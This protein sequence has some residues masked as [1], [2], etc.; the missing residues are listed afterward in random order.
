VSGDPIE[1]LKATTQARLDD[2]HRGIRALVLTDFPDYGN[3]GDSAIALGERAYWLSSGIELL[4][5]HSQPTLPTKVF[6]GMTPVAINGGGN[7]GGL[8]PN[9]DRHRYRLAERLRPGVPLV[10]EPQTVQFRDSDD[11]RKFERV[12]ASRVGA[13]IAVR[14]RRSLALVHKHMEEVVLSPDP[15]HM[16]GRVESRPPITDTLVLRRADG[17]SRGGIAQGRDWPNDSPAL[18]RERWWANRS[19]QIAP[20]K[21]LFQYT[22]DQWMSK[23]EQRFQAGVDYLSQGETVVTDRLH[24][25]LMALQMG[26]KV[27]AYDNSY[28]KLSA[29]AETWLG[30]YGD[31]LELRGSR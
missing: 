1:G 2:L 25:M 13:R 26:R 23:A 9:A 7:L 28:G 3:I 20:L 27:V 11:E 16:L 22:P 5:V 12:F 21:L 6:R 24:A 8:Y 15:V 14:D 4:A 30:G 17:E 31:Q 18:A 10:Q 29:Y 19:R